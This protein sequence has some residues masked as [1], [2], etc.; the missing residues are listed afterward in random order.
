MLEQNRIMYRFSG[1]F[2]KNSESFN[3][4]F[5]FNVFMLQWFEVP[6]ITNIFKRF[7]LFIFRE[8]ERNLAHNVGLCPDQELNR[9]PFGLQAG[10]QFTEPY[11]P[12]PEIVLN[13]GK[14]NLGNTL[15][16]LGN[17][18]KDEAQGV[19]SWR[20]YVLPGE[21]K[22]DCLSWMMPLHPVNT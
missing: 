4:P 2:V 17:Q 12:G 20:S 8:R 13:C 9:R 19:T 10:A 18:E 14:R 22:V 3:K 5:K 16:K 6:Q 7:C 1:L 15:A 21:R 11:Q